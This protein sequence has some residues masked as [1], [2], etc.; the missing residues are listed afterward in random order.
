M[1]ECEKSYFCAAAPI[2]CLCGLLAADFSAITLT[3][4]TMFG[5]FKWG[6][7]RSL[8]LLAPRSIFTRVRCACDAAKIKVGFCVTQTPREVKGAQEHSSRAHLTGKAYKDKP[9]NPQIVRGNGISILMRLIYNAVK[10]IRHVSRT[11]S[12][13]FMMRIN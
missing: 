10:L 8:S 4:D 3:A 13:G 9:L 5:L 11:V 12:C 2:E 7:M 1:V 6:A